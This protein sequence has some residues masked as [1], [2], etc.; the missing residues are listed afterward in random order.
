MII[1]GF[2]LDR[3]MP[4]YGGLLILASI[5]AIM[6]LSSGRSPIPVVIG[7]YSFF[8]GVYLAIAPIVRWLEIHMPQLNS[9]YVFL[10]FVAYVDPWGNASS[11]GLQVINSWYAISNG[12]IFG[13]GLGNSIQKLGRLPEPNTDFIMAVI[14][15]ELGLIGVLVILLLTFIIIFRLV[16]WGIRSQKS[17][18][19]RLALYGFA[20]YLLMQVFI[21]FGGVIGVLPITGVTYPFISYGGSSVFSLALAMGVSLN[22]IKSAKLERSRREVA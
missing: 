20:A 3:Y 1:A 10:R 15:E 9:N 4:D 19:R 22:L 17:P 14:A 18:F 16:L 13:R 21:N 11:S 5:G 8:I 7:G 2:V 12:G 6:L